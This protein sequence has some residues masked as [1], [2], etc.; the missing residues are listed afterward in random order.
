VLLNFVKLL[1][2]LTKTSLGEDISFDIFYEFKKNEKKYI[3][4]LQYTLQKSKFLNETT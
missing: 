3:S 2:I 1:L 4:A